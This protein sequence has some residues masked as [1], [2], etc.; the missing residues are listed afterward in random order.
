MSVCVLHTRPPSTPR[1]VRERTTGAGVRVAYT[2]RDGQ[3][4]MGMTEV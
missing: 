2:K 1:C 4:C 3:K